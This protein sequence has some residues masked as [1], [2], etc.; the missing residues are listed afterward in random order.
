MAFKKRKAAKEAKAEAENNVHLQ[1]E[2]KFDAAINA[3][4]KIKDPA[5]KIIELRKIAVGLSG[6]INAEKKNIKNKAGTREGVLSLAGNGAAIGAG[7]TVG[8]VL[9]G[10]V[11]WVAIP[12][13]LMGMSVADTIAE[14][15][16]R[17]VKRKL[18]SRSAEHTGKLLYQFEIVEKMTDET[19]DGNVREIVR[20]PL[21]QETLLLPGIAMKFSAAAVKHVANENAAVPDKSAKPQPDLSKKIV[22]A[23]KPE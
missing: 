8:A 18:E 10:P 9:G 19:I 22:K 13:A 11:A 17:K 1:E 15:R 3:A 14:N 4:D 21:Y 16:G 23:P 12:I 7:V 20:S 5:E 2:Q 6:L